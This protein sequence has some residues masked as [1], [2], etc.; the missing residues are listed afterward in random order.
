MR[1]YPPNIKICVELRGVTAFQKRAVQGISPVLC[2]FI[3]VKIFLVYIIDLEMVTTSTS[4]KA[5]DYP[6][7]LSVF[8]YS[9]LPLLAWV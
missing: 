3:Y 8:P 1:E 4:I 5:P 6:N 2:I 7:T 9:N